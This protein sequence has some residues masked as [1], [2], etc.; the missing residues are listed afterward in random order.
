MVLLDPEISTPLALG[1]KAAPE[2]SV[3]MA[4]PCTSVPAA[5]IERPAP[6]KLLPMTLPARWPSRR[7]C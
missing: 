4:L 1:R 2:A 5:L 6:E 7:W 3:P